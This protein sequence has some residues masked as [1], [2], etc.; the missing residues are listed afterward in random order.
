VVLS[1]SD[2]GVGMSPEVRD[3]IFEPFFTTKERGKGSGMGLATVY[4]IV[5]QHGGLIHVYSEP[6]QGTL[7][8]IYLPVM[9]SAANDPAREIAK[10]STPKNLQGAETILLAEDHDSI[11]ELT[12][13]SLTRLGYQVLA[14]ADGRQ[15]LRLAELERP[16]LAVLDV[17][18]PHMGGA[19]TAVQ[20]LQSMPG[21]PIL[22]TSGFSEN[23]NNAVALVPGSHYLQKPYGP[24]S[25]ASTIRE[26]LD[27]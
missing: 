11:R 25:L 13:Q 15:A 22:F 21:L 1:V 14:A 8:H 17:V 9:E 23:A 10:V 3:H 12:R 18:M 4:G 7:F 2:T 19:A 5:R 20:L 16:D 26:I 27:D 24:T 6:G